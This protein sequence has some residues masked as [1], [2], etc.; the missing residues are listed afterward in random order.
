MV[1]PCEDCIVLAFGQALVDAI[2]SL[3]DGL[4]PAQEAEPACSSFAF[5]NRG[6]PSRSSLQVAH[7]FFGFT[8]S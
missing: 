2:D 4:I 1:N 5:D 6:S 3:G 7:L 8:L